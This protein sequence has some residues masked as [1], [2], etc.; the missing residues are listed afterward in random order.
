MALAPISQ[1]AHTVS[2]KLGL[3]TDLMMIDHA[4]NLEI[5]SLRDVARIVALDN[6]S[7]VVETDSH[8]VMQE[9]SLRRKELV[10]KLNRHLPEPIL[11][12]ITVRITQSHGR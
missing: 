3:S 9:V 1:D 11:R 12:Y 2:R 8:T 5:G 7:L 4:W 10:R 6:A